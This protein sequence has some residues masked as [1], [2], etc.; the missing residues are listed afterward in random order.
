MSGVGAL[1]VTRQKLLDQR[2]HLAEA[3]NSRVARIPILIL[4]VVREPRQRQQQAQAAVLLFRWRDLLEVA[5][6]LHHFLDRVV[7]AAV[8]AGG[9]QVRLG[10]DAQQLHVLV[11]EDRV[12]ELSHVEVR[13]RLQRLNELEHV[14]PLPVEDQ[15]TKE[16]DVVAVLTIYHAGLS[17]QR[18]LRDVKVAAV[19][20]LQGQS[21][22]IL[23]AQRQ[24]RRRHH[25]PNTQPGQFP[26]QRIIASTFDY[27]DATCY[28]KFHR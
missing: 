24:V 21:Y 9:N 18:E 19:E 6:Y 22:H 25:V 14:V 8:R 10:L 1:S 16:Q 27:R 12:G 17:L 15:L 2:V 11:P 26:E 28:M 20:E 5:Q 4:Q 23:L 3:L 7:D 13:Q